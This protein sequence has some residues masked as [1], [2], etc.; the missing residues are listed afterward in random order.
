MFS[1]GAFLFGHWAPPQE[2]SRMIGLA[3]SGLDF[4]SL[5]SSI[6]GG[7]LCEHGFYEGW[8]SIFIIFGTSSC[9][10]D[11]YKLHKMSLRNFVVFLLHFKKRCCRSCVGCVV[12]SARFRVAH[13]S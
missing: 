9:Y 4:G 12:F 11:K 2:K 3:Q 10:C 13:K 7:I 1:S 8:G 5:V 6:F